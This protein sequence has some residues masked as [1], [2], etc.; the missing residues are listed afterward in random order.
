[1]Y[2][3]EYPAPMTLT[4]RGLWFSMGA[5]LQVNAVARGSVLSGTAISVTDTS[6]TAALG[7]MSVGGITVLS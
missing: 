1:M 7:A 5:S 2:T 4:L 6:G 3:P